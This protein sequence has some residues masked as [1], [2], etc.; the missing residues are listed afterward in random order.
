MPTHHLELLLRDILL[1]ALLECNNISTEKYLK[2][3]TETD[4]IY[5]GFKRGSSIKKT[6]MPLQKPANITQEALKEDV[7]A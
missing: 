4:V 5:L 6:C 2:Y 3:Q 1:I 7:N